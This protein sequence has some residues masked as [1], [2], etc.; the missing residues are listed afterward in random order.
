MSAGPYW[1]G[2]IDKRWILSSMP[3][4]TGAGSASG[5]GGRRLLSGAVF[6][7]SNN[8]QITGKKWN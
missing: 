2:Q 8:R 6:G 4:P 7:I 3:A 5:A 1:M